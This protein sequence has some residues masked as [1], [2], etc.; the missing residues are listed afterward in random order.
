MKK[1]YLYAMMALV[2]MS[3]MSC[4]KL[5]ESLSKSMLVQTIEKI[6]KNPE[7]TIQQ[8]DSIM[9]ADYYTVDG[10]LKDF[11]TT[12]WKREGVGTITRYHSE[13]NELCLLR[14]TATANL[15][16]YNKTYARMW[17]VGMKTLLGDVST[18]YTGSYDEVSNITTYDDFYKRLEEEPAKVATISWGTAQ[19]LLNAKFSI[20]PGGYPLVYKLS[21]TFD[22][23]RKLKK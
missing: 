22:H 16:F 14:Y 12:T 13:G 8:V 7:Y 18:G 6:D 9:Q 1:I 17:F 23:N 15:E 20:L 21:F 11:G 2:A 19:S 4:E 10:E 3:T 5:A